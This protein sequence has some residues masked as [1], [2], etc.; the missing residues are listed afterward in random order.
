MLR[1]KKNFPLSKLTTLNLGGPAKYFYFAKTQK[2]LIEA[3]KWAEKEQLKYL[4]IGGGSNLLISDEGFDGLI[5]KNTEI[6]ITQNSNIITVKAGTTLQTLVDFTIGKGLSGINKMAGI[7]GTVGGAVYGNAGAFGQTIS[8]CVKAVTCLDPSSQNSVRS[9]TILSKKECGFAYRDSIFKRN[10]HII[11]EVEFS[12]PS[13]DKTI[14]KQESKEVLEK[15]LKKYPPDML[16]P[17]SFFK[18][19]VA[20]QLPKGLKKRLAS[21]ITYGKISAGRLIELVGG[22]GDKLGKI[23]I[24]QNHGNTFINLGGGTAADFYSL[25]QKYYRKVK[26]EFRITLEPEVQLIALPPLH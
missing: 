17:G 9:Y 14:L 25:A 15:R 19:I 1:L 3:I 5:I 11:L 18:N 23:T 7:P 4:V 2:S 13:A 26:K 6:G 10:K 16:C 8:D 24:A 12:L 21:E 20:E 22:K